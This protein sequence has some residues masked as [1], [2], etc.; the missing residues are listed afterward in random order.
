MLYTEAVEQWQ[1]HVT[2]ARPVSTGAIMRLYRWALS[3]GINDEL[4]LLHR[5][6][7]GGPQLRVSILPQCD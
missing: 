1:K 4:M 5:L 2:G 7:R 3:D 6:R